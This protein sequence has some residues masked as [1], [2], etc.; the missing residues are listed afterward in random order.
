[1]R[2]KLILVA[3]DCLVVGKVIQFNLQRAGYH[4]TWVE[5]GQQAWDEAQ[6]EQFDTW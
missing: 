1:M 3:E 5:N 6:A 2:R 4:V